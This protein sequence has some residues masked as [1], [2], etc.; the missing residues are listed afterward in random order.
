MTSG[1]KSPLHELALGLEDLHIGRQILWYNLLTGDFGVYEILGPP[2]KEYCYDLHRH[3]LVIPLKEYDTEWR[4]TPFLD[5]MGVI[6]FAEGW[7]MLNFVV[8]YDRVDRENFWDH[9]PH[10]IG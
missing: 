8:D 6:P 10:P 5:E 9:L 3:R 2:V 4:E 1:Q 7:H